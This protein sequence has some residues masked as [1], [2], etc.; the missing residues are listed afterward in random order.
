MQ[1]NISDE[2]VQ[3]IAGS[4]TSD[5]FPLIPEGEYEAACVKHEHSR[6]LAKEKR[7][8]LHYQIISGEFE[9]TKLFQAFNYNY[10]SFSRASK[11]YVEWSLANKALPRRR[12]KMSPR[13]FLNKAF[14][15]KVVTVKPKHG[16]GTV[17]P[18]MFHYSKVDRIIEVLT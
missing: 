8:Y 15:V 3:D 4:A 16:D 9:A 17:K 12:D 18:E 7:L 11:Y 6:Y 5:P 13:V 2:E 10:K 1:K 14:K